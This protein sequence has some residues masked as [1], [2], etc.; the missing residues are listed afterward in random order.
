MEKLYSITVILDDEIIASDEQ[1]A[2]EQAKEMIMQGQYRL[3]IDSEEE[4]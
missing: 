1:E 4:L 3:E 2:L